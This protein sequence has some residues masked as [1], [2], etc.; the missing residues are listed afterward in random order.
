MGDPGQVDILQGTLNMMILR[1]LQQG[2]AKGGDGGN[3]EDAGGGGAGMGGA[4][5]NQGTLT[6]EGVTLDSNSA[7]GGAGGVFSSGIGGGGGGG[8]GIAM[9]ARAIRLGAGR[10]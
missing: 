10:S 3:G 6:L 8:A 9:A 2:E 5:F 7:V 4:I 1:V